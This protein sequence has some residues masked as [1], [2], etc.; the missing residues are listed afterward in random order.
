MCSDKAP[1][2]EDRDEPP[3]PLPPEGS[4]RTTVEE[5]RLECGNHMVDCSTCSLSENCPLHEISPYG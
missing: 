1:P 4:L 3:P 2:P 5:A